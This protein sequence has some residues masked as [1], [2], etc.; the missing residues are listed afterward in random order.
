MDV[1]VGAGVSGLAYA[2]FSKNEC[3]LL[4]KDAEIGGYCKTIKWGD[5][6]WDYSGHFFHFRDTFLEDYICRNMVHD[7]I[8][9]C[10]KHTQIFYRQKYIDFPF[11]KNIH[12]LDQDEF[13]DCLYDLFTTTGNDYF[14]FK[15]MLYAKFGQSIA[16]K[17]LIPYNEKLYAC[18]LNRLDVDAMGRFFPYADKEEIIRNF[19]KT[20][21]NSYNRHFTYPRGGA[22]EYVKSL[23][24]Y[25][26]KSNIC[27]NECVKSIDVTE[28][29]IKTDKREL[30]Y[31]NLI[32]TMPFP[33]LMQCCS[34]EYDTDIYS[35]NKVLV[36]NLGFDK[37]GKDVFNNWIYVPSKDF[38]FYRVGYYDNIFATKNMSLYVELGFGKNTDVIDVEYYKEKVLDDLKKAGIITDHKLIASHFVIMD[39]AYVHITKES[40]RDVEEKKKVLARN[41]I[42][43][44]GR[45]GSWTY[46]SIEDN[47]LEAKA[48]MERLSD[49]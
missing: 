16:E 22:I 7:D 3:L 8:R 44:I 12:Q 25:I 33:L 19:K 45:Y 48:L 15:Q 39:P 2:G 46:C 42:Y 4:E 47:I 10:E 37:K 24:S 35:W 6:V 1:I 9:Y 43:S 17:F 40:I 13:I 32:S 26:G 31:D 38:C 30:K 49:Y 18:D 5:F 29:T 28:K 20:N 36:F 14:T 41:N 34:M 11:Q 23:A 21:N 27:L